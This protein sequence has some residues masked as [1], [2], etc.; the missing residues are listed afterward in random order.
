MVGLRIGNSSM[1]AALPSTR[2]LSGPELCVGTS[3]K[4]IIIGAPKPGFTLIELLVVI[5]IIAILAAMLLPALAKAKER[6]LR[7][8]CS[9][10]LRQ[11]GIGVHMYIADHRDALPPSHWPKNANPWRTYEVYRVSG[12]TGIIQTPEDVGGPWN[13]GLLFA[14]KAVPNA[15]VFYC[16]S[17]K[18][19]DASRTYEYYSASAPWP[20]TPVGSA[21][22]NVRTG[23]NYFPQSKKLEN[24]GRGIELP[25]IVYDSKNNPFPLKV[26]QMDPNRSISTDLVQNL[27]ASPHK[28]KSIAGLNTL[29]GDGHVKFQNARSNPKAFDPALWKDSSAADYIGNNPFN[30]RLVMSYW[31]P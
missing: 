10:N 6:A 24:V 3:S 26:S 1:K 28:D 21:D 19:T 16:P 23:Y 14:T 20:S 4:R 2:H 25:E 29:F 13:L 5:A 30:F 15:R 9:S 12:G 11:I 31:L 7:I 27:N 22:D 18:N 17:G 8:N